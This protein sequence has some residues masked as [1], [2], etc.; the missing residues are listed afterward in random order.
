MW[1]IKISR[2]QGWH[3][4]QIEIAGS[5]LPSGSQF[6]VTTER[7]NPAETGAVT[8]SATYASFASSVSSMKTQKI[9]LVLEFIFYL[10]RR[11]RTRSRIPH[12]LTKLPKIGEF[13]NASKTNIKHQ[14]ALKFQF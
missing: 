11:C 1:K 6:S 3:I 13:Q 7:K 4:I 2:A 12:L 8:G 10:H 14:Q 5:K 9:P